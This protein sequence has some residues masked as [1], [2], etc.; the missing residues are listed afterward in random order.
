MLAPQVGNHTRG[1]SRF[2]A[3]GM[4]AWSLSTGGH[5]FRC[6]SDARLELGVLASGS[7]CTAI[8]EYE[9]RRSGAWSMGIALDNM[10]F[11]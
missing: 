9:A 10:R 4:A 6:Y 7:G 11:L 1:C 2:W 8:E 3:E 5:P